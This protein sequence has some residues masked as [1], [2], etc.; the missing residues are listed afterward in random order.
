MRVRRGR[1]GRQERR[2]RKFNI[3]RF[4][5]ESVPPNALDRLRAVASARRRVLVPPPPAVLQ[6]LDSTCSALHHRAAYA[7]GSRFPR[8]PSASPTQGQRRPASVIDKLLHQGRCQLRLHAGEQDPTRARAYGVS[9]STCHRFRVQCVMRPFR[10]LHWAPSVAAY[11]HLNPSSS[12][13]FFVTLQI[14]SR[15]R[16]SQ[17]PPWSLVWMMI[18][19]PVLPSSMELLQPNL[20]AVF[21]EELRGRSWSPILEPLY[22][23]LRAGEKVIYPA[24]QLQEGP[25]FMDALWDIC[26]PTASA[27]ARW[28]Y[29]EASSFSSIINSGEIW[30]HPLANRMDEGELMDFA[31]E[32][33]LKG[34]SKS[35]YR[36]ARAAE[37]FYLSLTDQ[38]YPGEWGQ[39]DCFWNYGEVRLRLRVEPVMTRA[40][41][42]KVA[43]SCSGE[44]PLKALE[45]VAR[46]CFDRTFMPWGVSR[47]G[48]FFLREE[49]S[50]ESE[51]RLLLKRF[52][53]TTDLTVRQ[54]HDGEVVAIPL[55]VRTKRV[56]IDLLEVQVQKEEDLADVHSLVENS[57]F[58]GVNVSV[59]KA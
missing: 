43:Y 38:E 34:F 33:G 45:A 5:W 17:F 29:T 53:Q 2:R 16:Q 36:D 26:F 23:Q 37:L 9:K 30:L 39:P 50:W 56:Q 35:D 47:N 21:A 57:R 24:R 40:H 11:P 59:F 6:A 19:L 58:C 15:S 12:R 31:S 32:F 1:T 41:L 18:R 7:A 52:H 54:V 46:R 44:H 28:H 8:P 27:G 10:W 20:G 42:R 55:G 14:A 22:G 4:G 13:K 51:V 49:H 25:V 48:A 3:P